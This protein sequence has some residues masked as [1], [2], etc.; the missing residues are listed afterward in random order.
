MKEVGNGNKSF[1]YSL[2]FVLPKKGKEF[3]LGLFL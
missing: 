1:E 2:Y 3:G